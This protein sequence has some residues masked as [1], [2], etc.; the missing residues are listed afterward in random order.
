[1]LRKVLIANR[2]EIAVRVIR[3]LREMNIPSVAV[4]SDVDRHALHVRMADEAVGI[5]GAASA[6]SYLRMDK[7]IDAARKVGADS[8]HPGYG[9]LSENAAFAALCEKEGLIFIGPP[10]SAIEQLGSKTSARQLAKRAGT[11]IPPGTEEALNNANEAKAI[12]REVG[13]PV[14][15]KAASGGGGKGMRRVEREEDLEAAFRDAS[16]EAERSFR[17]S[18]VYIEKFIVRPRH[19][20]IQI[21]GDHHGNMIYL[22]ERECSIQRRHQ[23]VVEEAPSPFIVNHPELRAK[24]GEAAVAAAK[25]AG[26]TNA[27]TCEFLVDIH[28][29]FYFLEMN[30]R[31]QVEHPVTESITSID[32]VKWQLRIAAGE[33]LTLKQEDIS[34]RGWS[35]ECRL[36]AEDAD[37]GF[38]PSPGEITS[39]SL[40]GGPGVRLDS[41]VYPGWKVPLEYDP[42]LIKLVAWAETREDVVHRLI[43]ALEET[44]IGGIRTNVEFFLDLLADTEFLAADLH[45]GFLDE[46]FTRR[47]KHEFTP[48]E[49]EAAKRVSALARRPKPQQVH[50]KSK[51]KELPLR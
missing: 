4:F 49:I 50:V 32:L 31:L 35:M 38:L 14:I 34:I 29:N 37:N 2:G 42:L 24:M 20:E 18:A 41:G 27:G 33:K 22:G 6:D 46:W 16:S 51:W 23:K 11:P 15:L 28:G 21:L 19:I 12:A 3:A 13:Y 36:Y 5:G 17:D 45:T 10:S 9:F 43:R 47:K 26:Y 40:P 48:A 25:E 7:I 44:H 1:M 8:I 30:T 39:L